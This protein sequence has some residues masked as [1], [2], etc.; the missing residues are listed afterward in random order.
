M[1]QFL[2]FQ[3][4][5]DYVIP[6]GRIY[7]YFFTIPH[8]RLF[9]S[10]FKVSSINLIV[11][12]NTLHSITTN[13]GYDWQRSGNKMLETSLDF[14]INITSTIL[15]IGNNLF[16]FYLWSGKIQTFS[17]SLEH[18]CSAECSQ[19]HVWCLPGYCRL[20]PISS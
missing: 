18:E 13:T 4:L 3:W 8:D 6:G 11:K 7:I 19:F 15:L 2:Q 10:V 12:V 16:I 20:R 9:V 1:S 17:S 14:N 5:Y